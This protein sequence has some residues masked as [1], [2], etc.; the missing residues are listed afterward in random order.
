MMKESMIQVICGPGKG[1]STSAMG[2]GIS[3]LAKGS[4]V[5][6]V[7]F[8]KGSLDMDNMEI[9][10]RLEPE[11]KIFRFE[12]TPVFFDRLTEEEKA[13]ARICILNGLNFARKVL[14]LTGNDVSLLKPA[15]AEELIGGKQRPK[16]SILENL[17]M[18][19]TEIYS[20]P[21]WETDLE[22]YLEVRGMKNG[23]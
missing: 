9:L 20:M 4:N 15:L 19:M 12:K 14:E 18:K 22:E 10:K 21:Q 2:R 16:Y 7:Q 8:L 23:R 17:M 5:I 13:E 1:K 6:M 11:F 3:A